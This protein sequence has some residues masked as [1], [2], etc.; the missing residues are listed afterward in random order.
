MSPGEALDLRDIH[1][2]PE[3]GLWPPASG[4][5]LLALLVVTLLGW[6]ALRLRRYLLRRRLQQQVLA[7]LAALTGNGDL[8]GAA[9]DVSALLKRVALA[10]FPRQEVASLTGEPWL[11]FLDRTG[12]EGRFRFGPGRPLA[13]APYAREGGLALSPLLALAREWVRHNL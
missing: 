3:P 2:P 11:A 13:E 9:A 7:E 5:W 1:L 8:A 6:L 10:R 4:W 12:G